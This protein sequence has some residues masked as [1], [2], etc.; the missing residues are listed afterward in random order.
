MEE[1]TY[2]QWQLLNI[3]KDCLPDDN[4]ISSYGARGK[5]QTIIFYI[6]SETEDNSL[7]VTLE[8]QI[9]EKYPTIKI[10]F[11]RGSWGKLL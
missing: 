6:D 11:R 10:E 2:S 3:A 4:R 7:E 8:K 5:D 9:R 1:V